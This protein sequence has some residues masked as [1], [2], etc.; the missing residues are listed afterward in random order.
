MVGTTKWAG[1]YADD[2]GWEQIKTEDRRLETED[3]RLKTET[4]ED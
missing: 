4:N 2:A 3:R 1:G